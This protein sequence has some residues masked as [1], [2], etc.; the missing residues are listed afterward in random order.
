MRISIYGC[1]GTGI[2]RAADLQSVMEESK[3]DHNTPFGKVDWYAVS[4]SESDMAPAGPAFKQWLPSGID[5]AGKS[6]KNAVAVFGRDDTVNEIF[7]QLPP[8]DV[9]II[10][11]STSGGT[12]PIASAAFANEILKRG[13]TP[14]MVAIGSEGSQRE[15]TNTVNSLKTFNNTAKRNKAAMPCFFVSRG[16]HEQRE[17]VDV[18][19]RTILRH[20]VM[21]ISGEHDQLDGEDIKNALNPARVYTDIR[22]GLYRLDLL[23]YDAADD[24][25]FSRAGQWVDQS[26]EVNF[27]SFYGV[28]DST[29]TLR[30]DNDEDP[31]LAFG[32]AIDSEGFY[33]GRSWTSETA[34]SFVLTTS[35]ELMSDIYAK[36]DAD[37]EEY[38][39]IAES[40]KSTEEFDADEDMFCV[41]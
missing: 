38:L 29:I 12:G 3:I 27:E 11:T 22:T 9:C 16:N 19:A 28:T 10:I 21:T 6:Q 7:K 36:T 20:L 25:W 13:K 39:R 35:F 26:V 23:A 2:N 30:K 14:V 4:T 18:E 40:R 34:D 24:K 17:A 15:A 5:G 33:R 32:Q 8:A 31:K 37:N 1:G 41:D